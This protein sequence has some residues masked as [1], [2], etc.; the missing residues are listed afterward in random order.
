MNIVSIIHR[1][2]LVKFVCMYNLV[3]C[4]DLAL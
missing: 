4:I 3:E 1:G 2:N